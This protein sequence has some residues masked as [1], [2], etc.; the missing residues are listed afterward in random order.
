MPLDRG[1][2]WVNAA[3]LLQTFGIFAKSHPQNTVKHIFNI[4]QT[5]LIVTEYGTEREIKN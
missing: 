4:N 5:I 3:T 1:Y 2:L